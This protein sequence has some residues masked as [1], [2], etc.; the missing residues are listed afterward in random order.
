MIGVTQTVSLTRALLPFF[1][2]LLRQSPQCRNKQHAS[3]ASGTDTT[4]T[5]KPAHAA[6]HTHAALV[7]TCH[8]C[9]EC[10]CTRIHTDTKHTQCT[11]CRSHTTTTATE[12]S[13]HIIYRSFSTE[14][15]RAHAAVVCTCHWCKARICTR[16]HRHIT[17]TDTDADTLLVSNAPLQWP[18]RSV[19]IS[20]ISLSALHQLDK[21]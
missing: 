9:K 11:V 21:S 8:S 3:H 5:F 1:P 7:C 19:A 17:R 4:T 15:G 2:V 20:S 16:T 12:I 6:M 14:I 13:G 18:P 10:T